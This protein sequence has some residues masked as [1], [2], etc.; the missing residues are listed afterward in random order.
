MKNVESEFLNVYIIIICESE[1]L[2]STLG[3]N[4]PQSDGEEVGL[5]V[6]LKRIKGLRSSRQI[7]AWMI[8]T[9]GMN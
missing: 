9:L 8:T 7:E 3:A 2:G 1:A 5:K 4:R 6:C